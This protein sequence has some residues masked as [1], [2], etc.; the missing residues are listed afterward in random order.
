FMSGSRLPIFS[1]EH[2]LDDQPDYVLMLV[3]NIADEII[4]LQS[5]YRAR[6]GRFII[7]VPDLVIV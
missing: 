4:N 7:P 1:V 5:E 2:L 6:G 3:W